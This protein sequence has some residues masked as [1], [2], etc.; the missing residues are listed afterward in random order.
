[1]FSSIVLVLLTFETIALFCPRTGGTES[2]NCSSG[3]IGTRTAEEANEKAREKG[4]TE[5]DRLKQ[6]VEEQEKKV[7]LMTPHCHLEIDAAT[8]Q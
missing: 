4:K 7:E 1:L 6:Y 8:K 3:H 5:R 2:P